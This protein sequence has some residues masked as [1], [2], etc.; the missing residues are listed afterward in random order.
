MLFIFFSGTYLATF[1]KLGIALWGG[2]KFAQIIK[3]A[4]EG[5]S[6]IDFSPCEK[7]LVTFSPLLASQNDP[8]AIIIW[9]VRTGISKRAFHSDQEKISWPVVKW[10]PDD[11]YFAKIGPDILSVYE[12]PSMVLLDKKS[13]KISGVKN[14]SWSPSH[15]ILAYWV[16]EDKDV[17][18]RV[19]LL[20]IP[21]K[22]E[23]R[24]K[25]LFNVADCKMHWQK[26]GD[27]LCVKVDRYTKVKKEKNDFKYSG[28]FFN[29]EVF[30]MQK[31]D[32]PVDSLEIK[33]KMNRY[34]L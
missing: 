34:H 17:P 28:M 1:H 7:Y 18:A 29:F 19:T 4:H 20:E 8:N 21:S 9:D 6:H 12:T 31:K 5:V 14:F 26:S 30:D 13:M 25:N 22:N 23:L 15:N 11:K 16:A 32:I 33:G 10:S 24:T 3:F 2:E 27:Y